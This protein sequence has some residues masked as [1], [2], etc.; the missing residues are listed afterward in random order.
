MELHLSGG[1]GG[2]TTEAKAR[3]VRC[4]KVKGMKVL[5]VLLSHF[6]LSVSKGPCVQDL[7]PRLVKFGSVEAL[8]GSAATEGMASRGHCG[9]EFSLCLP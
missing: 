7:V 3:S 6:E 8:S 1:W 5:T 2:Q 9:I 4:W